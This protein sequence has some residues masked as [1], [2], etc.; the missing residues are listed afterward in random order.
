MTDTEIII[1]LAVITIAV[2]SM[3]LWYA[4][5]ISRGID[6]VIKRCESLKRWA[7]RNLDEREGDHH[8]G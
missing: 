1:C 2:I 5:T 7:K 3:S 4:V 6:M 8:E